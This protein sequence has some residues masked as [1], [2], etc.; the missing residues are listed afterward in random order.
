V[1]RF[2]QQT[3]GGDRCA[4]P[5]AD[6]L[7]PAGD[8]VPSL[9]SLKPLGQLRES[10]ILAVNDEGLWIVDQHVAHERVLF[11]R[12]LRQRSQQQVESQRLLMPMVI[13]LTPAQQA[14]FSEISD[15]LQKNGFETEPFGA[16]SIAI[17]IAPAGVQAGEVEHMLHE[18]LDQFSREEQA[19]N[20]EQIRG[21]IAASIACHAAIKVNMPL[22]QNKM[23]WLLA[24]LAK[25]ECPMSCPHG[26][27]V[28]LRYSMK[29][30]QKA[31]KRI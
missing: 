8:A 27:P 15:E 3:F 28:V 21:R 11:E 24:E 6:E 30:I 12:V 31:F 9:S 26:R 22:E 20:L 4:P 2:P 25:T 29:D 5:L 19:L 14:V 1:A 18:L 16:R 13:E 23:E 7:E 17:K 10:F